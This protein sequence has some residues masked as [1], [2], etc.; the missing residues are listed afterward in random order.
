[1]ITDKAILHE[2]ET[3]THPSLKE[4]D[5]HFKTAHNIYREYVRRAVLD[6]GGPLAISRALA[7]PESTVRAIIKRDRISKLRELALEIER[8]IL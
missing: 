6:N 7:L 5:N 4:A 3:M 2:A 1:M 8:N